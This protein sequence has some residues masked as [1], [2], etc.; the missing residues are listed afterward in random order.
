MPSKTGYNAAKVAVRLETRRA[1]RMVGPR[2]EWTRPWMKG[3]V[4]NENRH[5]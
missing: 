2:R 4:N 5:G 1:D 3:R